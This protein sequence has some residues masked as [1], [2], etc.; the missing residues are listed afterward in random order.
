MSTINN[1]LYNIGNAQ[2]TKIKT[3]RCPVES[4]EEVVDDTKF[5]ISQ[6]AGNGDGNEI[7]EC[8]RACPGLGIHSTWSESPT[9]ASTPSSS[10]VPQKDLSRNFQTYDE[11]NKVLCTS[12]HTCPGIPTVP[13]SNIYRMRADYVPHEAANSEHV[14]Y[15]TGGHFPTKAT[16]KATPPNASNHLHRDKLNPGTN[17]IV[18]M[19]SID[20]DDTE[21][22]RMGTVVEYYEERQLYHLFLI[23]R[24]TSFRIIF[25]STLQLD[26]DTIRY[27]LSIDGC[28]QADLDERLS[29]LY[30]LNPEEGVGC[31]NCPSLTRKVINSEKLMRNIRN[32]IDNVSGGDHPTAGISFFCGSDTGDTI[33]S[34]LCL[35]S[36]E[37][38]GRDLYYGSKQGR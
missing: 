3:S 22:K 34:R 14:S 6:A 28:S 1:Y 32:I 29:R 35:R 33:A 15:A 27:Y 13:L 10:N 17:T 12:D 8:A 9:V 7:R 26:K 31:G 37:A 25:V 20:L 2:T 30:L 21:L 36:L 18:V 11:D 5:T 24:D 4:S 23:V 19:P 38:S 16:N